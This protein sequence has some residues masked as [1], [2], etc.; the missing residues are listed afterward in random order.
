MV[1]TVLG[2]VITPFALPYSL[3]VYRAQ[4]LS[5]VLAATNLILE[6]VAFYLLLTAPARAWFKPQNQAPTA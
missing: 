6:I 3:P 2:L 4:P 5:A 1:L